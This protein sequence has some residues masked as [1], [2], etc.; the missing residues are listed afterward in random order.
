MLV[1][2]GHEREF[3]QK[4]RLTLY[5]DYAF[6]ALIYLETQKDR[7]VSIHEIARV[8]DISENHLVKVI[9]R[10]GK[11]GFI[12][13]QRGRRGGIRSHREAADIKLGDVVRCTED[14]MAIVS[15]MRCD[16]SAQQCILTIRGCALQGVLARARDAFMAELDKLTLA[17]M[18]TS[19][20]R[21]TLHS[22]YLSFV[23]QQNLE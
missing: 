23:E 7:L 6:R 22:A 18:I 9:H 5:T 8:Y 4:M 11:H 2:I 21:R 15:C 3:S 12:E 1:G 14:D 10:L 20:E 16:E 13:T 19:R 17:D